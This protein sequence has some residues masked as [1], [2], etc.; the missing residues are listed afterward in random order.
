MP[1]QLCHPEL[2]SGSCH[3]NIILSPENISNIPFASHAAKRK[4]RGDYVPPEAAFT[5]AEV[6][7]TL[8]IIGIIAVMTLPTLIAKY[9]ERVILTRVKK[10][11]S[12]ILSAV[13]LYKAENEVSDIS[14]L[15]DTSNT[16]EQTMR[17][18]AK[19]FKTIEICSSSDRK[20]CHGQ[21]MILP[22][23]K[24]SD[25]NGN[26]ASDVLC[27]KSR[28]VLPDG[29]LIGVIQYPNCYELVEKDVIDENGFATGEKTK[30][31]RSYCAL[32]FFDVN[33]KESPN[34]SGQDY[35]CLG[36]NIDGSIYDPNTFWCGSI[37]SVL[38]T[39][40]L[41]DVENYNFGSYK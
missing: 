16:S 17:N 3:R 15:F 7:I 39:D 29:T 1:K 5:L 40:K 4:V 41:N 28:F 6:L 19:Y 31:V 18:F 32:L 14:G 10:V 25:G 8:G 37:S 34:R 23:R 24:L 36:I 21:Y 35:F 20:G 30:Y 12:Q 11:Y 27:T 2:D 26:T 9:Q 13:S 38:A 33:G 22:K